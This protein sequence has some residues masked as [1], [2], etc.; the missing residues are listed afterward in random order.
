[1]HITKAIKITQLA[2]A[3]PQIVMV[4]MVVALVER[5]T[6][7]ILDEVDKKLN[8]IEEQRP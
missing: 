3:A 6:P 5:E 2:I 1:M 8:L 4:D 7:L